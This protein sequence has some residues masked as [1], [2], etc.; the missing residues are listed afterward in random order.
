MKVI[1]PVIISE[2]TPDGSHIVTVPDLY[3][4]G[5]GTSGKDMAEA[6]YMA[7]EFI[8]IICIDLQDDGIP[9]PE[10]FPMESIE[11]GP[12]DIVTLVDV[13]LTEYRRATEQKTVRRNVSLPAWMDY[14][15]EKAGI[16]VSAL[17]QEAI[18]KELNLPASRK[19]RDKQY[20][21]G[22]AQPMA[23]R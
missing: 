8:G 9:L 15:A 4:W 20:N 2:K 11:R 23:M 17:L 13:D 12:G 16:N 6:L 18:A 7:R 21:A 19:K 5:T 1:Y 22:T 14:R 3:E 10:P